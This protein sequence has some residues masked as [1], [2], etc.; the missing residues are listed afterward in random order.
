MT[1]IVALLN[2]YPAALPPIDRDALVLCVQECLNCTQ[3]STACADACLADLGRV[4]LARCT[5]AALDCADLTGV[6]VRMV[7]RQT[8]YDAELLRAV[9]QACIEACRACYDECRKH[10]LE[11]EH[12][13]VC[14]E[15][16][17][18]CAKACRE[19]LTTIK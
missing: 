6:T 17:Q 10:A 3:A 5:S 8:G 9:L 12:C 13:R 18:R 16:C 4:D 15:A 11:H 14:G 1:D 2:A 7:T 19:F